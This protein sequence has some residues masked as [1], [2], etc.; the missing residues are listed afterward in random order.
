VST[1][2]TDLFFEAC[3]WTSPLRLSVESADQPLATERILDQP[4]ALVGSD[5][6]M[7]LRLDD[8]QVNRRHAYLQLLGGKI[9]CID[10][11]SRFGIQLQGRTKRSEMMEPGEALR[12]GSCWI[13][14]LGSGEEPASAAHDSAGEEE[15][16]EVALEFVNRLPGPTVWRMTTTLALVGRAS[17]CRVRLVGASVSKFHCSLVR[18]PLGLWVVDLFGKGG[19]RVNEEPVRSARLE[20]GDRLQVGNFIIRTRHL[21]P[22]PARIPFSHLADVTEAPSPYPLPP[23]AGGEGR[24]RGSFSLP[25]LQETLLQPASSP[26][27]EETPALVPTPSVP[28]SAL[29]SESLPANA[30]IVQDLLVPVTQQLGMIQH[31]MFEQFQQ[32]MMMMFQMFGKLQHEQLGVIRDEMEHLRE[33]SKEVMT[34]QKE[35]AKQSQ[36]PPGKPRPAP[37]AA[38]PRAAPTGVSN[39]PVSSSAPAPKESA[40][41]KPLPHS[42]GQ[43]EKDMH[44]W[45]IQR[46]ATLQQERQSRWQR[47]M[48]FLGGLGYS[49][50]SDGKP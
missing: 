36:S 46:L 42:P 24:V 26:T 5:P 34:L 39:R 4:F 30:G 6:R 28:P 50:E 48:S 41:P 11:Q 43:P 9:S 38:A 35:L 40:L 44:A 20:E 10:L 15:L 3:R 25:A 17:L 13:R 27:Q 49:T 19:I 1:N 33:L 23:L 22:A 7:D 14:V 47:I 18:T 21:Q 29:S 37:A 2:S 32:A 12:I 31:Q 45:L 16:P 8:P